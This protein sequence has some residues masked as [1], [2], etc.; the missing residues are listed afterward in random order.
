MLRIDPSK[1]KNTYLLI[2][3]ALKIGEFVAMRLKNIY[4]MRRPAQVYPLIMPLIDG[5]DTPSFPS[6]HS[7]QAHLITGLLKLALNPAGCPDLPGPGPLPGPPA[8]PVT[9]TSDALDVLACRV[10]RNREIA[11]VHY[12][13]DSQAGLCGALKCLDHLNGLPAGGP[14]QTLLGLAADED[15]IRAGPSP[16]FRATA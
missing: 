3:V 14:F 13:M 5:P 8:A 1:H 6:S 4:R 12:P 11:G 10:A 2:L 7:L 15:V 9:T 16:S